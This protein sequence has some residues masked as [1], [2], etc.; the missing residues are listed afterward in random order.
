[1]VRDNINPDLE[2]SIQFHLILIYTKYFSMYKKFL[3]STNLLSLE[4]NQ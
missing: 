3:L 4:S 2:S 1:M